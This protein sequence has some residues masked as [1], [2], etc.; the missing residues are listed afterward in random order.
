MVP[1]AT[2]EITR[3]NFSKEQNYL[4]DRGLTFDNVLT[5]DNYNFVKIDRTITLDIPLNQTNLNNFLYNYVKVS[6]GNSVKEYYYFIDSYKWRNE[7]TILL[8][9]TI[10]VLNTFY[11]EILED[12]V[13]ERLF[14]SKCFI[15]RNTIPRFTD[16]EYYIIHEESE[17]ISV[18][19]D[20]VI[21][22]TVISTYNNDENFYI[23]KRT[24]P[25]GSITVRD[26]F[27]GLE[28]VKN[29]PKSELYFQ[30]ASDRRIDD[31]QAYDSNDLSEGGYK[32]SI[33]SIEDIDKYDNTII[34]IQRIPFLPFKNHLNNR[35]F[36]TIRYGN[37][38]NNAFIYNGFLTISYKILQKA[39]INA[40]ENTLTSELKT[41]DTINF[42]ID[43][44]TM[45]NLYST[46]KNIKYEPKMFHSDFYTYGVHYQDKFMA[47]SLEKIKSNQRANI[48][49]FGI[50]SNDIDTSFL[51][52]YNGFLYDDKDINYNIQK[53]DGEIQT[54][55]SEY[56]NYIRNG[57]NYD[58]KQRDR[59]TVNNI[60]SLTSGI[61]TT[62][63]SIALAPVTNGLSLVG[64]I[65]GASSIINGT[66]N[67]VSS[68]NQNNDNINRK[69]L[70]LQNT[71]LNASL[72]NSP[73]LIYNFSRTPKLIKIQ[74]SDNV[75]NKIFNYL[76]YNGYNIQ[77]YGVPTFNN[78]L[79]FDYIKM[80][81]DVTDFNPLFY[82]DLKNAFAKGVYIFHK[83]SNG[84]YDTTFTKENFDRV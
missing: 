23:I 65:S 72:V 61:V 52:K 15:E 46:P 51:L 82:Q 20:N 30:F 17:N 59:Q 39:L 81:I 4:F 11:R 41:I 18:T 68:I 44:P 19:K 5:V 66:V 64:G 26:I 71:T 6:N 38:F 62:G 33:A 78:R 76:Y 60:L 16:N 22:N 79:I 13:S 50:V 77:Q 8:N 21:S 9:C 12:E 34:S 67:T 73:S 83:K 31:F 14:T 49:L 32:F 35:K 3:V 40:N 53:Y 10:D 28:V 25:T 84:L 69:L 47:L 43:K 56:L 74:P 2:L 45:G 55:N 48:K 24:I 75:R 37:N 7:N 57:Y 1:V 58:K 80:D 70:E 54:F 63:A 42:K 36:L 29:N 27:R